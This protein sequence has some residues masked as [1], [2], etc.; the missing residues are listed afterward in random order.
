MYVNGGLTIGDN[1]HKSR[2]VSIYTSDYD[3]RRND[4]L[5]YGPERRTAVV[6]IGRN[7]WIGMNASILPGVI[8]GDGAI[9]AMGAVVSRDVAA[10][11]IVAQSPAAQIG[12]RDAE[13]YRT[14]DNTQRYGGRSGYPYEPS[15]AER[16]SRA[17][18][19]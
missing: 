10:M 4:Y 6:S 18:E 13:A 19:L 17:G 9:I 5:S 7:V 14:L 2:R 3:F 1:T 16:N 12:A 11:A 15:G 8:V